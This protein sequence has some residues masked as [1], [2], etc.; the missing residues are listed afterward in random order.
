[1]WRE[2]VGEVCAEVLLEGRGEAHDGLCMF[3]CLRHYALALRVVH[4]HIR[5]GP[6][7][8]YHIWDGSPILD[9]DAAR[10]VGVEAN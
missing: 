2:E 3:Q 5:V 7:E 10:M 4:H 6:A 9:Q 1:M 8:D